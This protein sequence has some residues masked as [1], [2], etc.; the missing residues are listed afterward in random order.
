MPRYFSKIGERIVFYHNELLYWHHFSFLFGFSFDYKCQDWIIR[1]TRTKK[2]FDLKKG[3]LGRF[4]SVKILLFS[5][6]FLDS[7]HNKIIIQGLIFNETLLVTAFKTPRVAHNKHFCLKILINT[8]GN[9]F[10]TIDGK[11]N[12]DLSE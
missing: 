5:L 11:T 8:N 9:H 10:K 4:A 2:W 6:I 3:I 1:R 12:I 7:Q